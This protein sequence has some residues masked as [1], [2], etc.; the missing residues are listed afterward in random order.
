MG[1]KS[2]TMRPPVYLSDGITFRPEYRSYGRDTIYDEKQGKMMP[3]NRESYQA[4]KRKIELRKA[5]HDDNDIQYTPYTAQE[6]SNLR[7]ERNKFSTIHRN[8]PLPSHLVPNVKGRPSTLEEL[9]QRMKDEKEK[10]YEEHERRKIEREREI[11]REIIQQERAKKDEEIIRY[12]KY[13]KRK[14]I[15]KEREKIEREERERYFED[16]KNNIIKT[17]HNIPTEVQNITKN[18]IRNT[19]KFG[20]NTI[21]N[22]QRIF[23]KGG[24]KRIPKKTVQKKRIPKETVQKRIPKKTVQKKRI[25]KET[26]QKRIPKKTVQK[27]IPKKTVQKRLPKEILQ[28]RIPK[29]T[30][31]KRIP[32]E[33]VQKKRI[34]KETVQKRIP[35]ETVQKKRIPKKTVQKRIPKKILQKIENL[36]KLIK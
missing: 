31:Q 29:E 28:K 11:Q 2:G 35:K 25:P 12:N 3:D 8:T 1:N 10:W 15:E 18:I 7:L 4:K 14:E 33:T 16:V 17:V 26:V 24:K 23:P 32:K 34:P 22:I 19:E 20:K 21:D 13:V 9:T 27:R 36:K 5:A 30:V 6:L